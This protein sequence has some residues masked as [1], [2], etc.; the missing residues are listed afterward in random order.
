MPHTRKKSFYHKPSSFSNKLFF[1]VGSMYDKSSARIRKNGLKSGFSTKISNNMAG[2]K[3]K[4]IQRARFRIEKNNGVRFSI[5]KNAT[6]QNL[7]KNFV[8]SDFE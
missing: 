7:K 6:R 4:K 3:R 2:F 8:L 1:D 5:E